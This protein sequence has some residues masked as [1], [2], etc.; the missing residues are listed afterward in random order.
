MGVYEGR[1]NLSKA[2]S[3]LIKKWL[4]TKVDWDDPVS[5]EFEKKFLEELEHDVKHT[6]GA[7]DVMANVM[8]QIKRDCE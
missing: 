4:D 8:N 1:G 6:V 2:V 3:E 7:L 5:E